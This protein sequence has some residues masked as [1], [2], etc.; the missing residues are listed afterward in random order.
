[1]AQKSSAAVAAETSQEPVSAS[2]TIP[3]E[4]LKVQKVNLEDF[5]NRLPIGIFAFGER[6]Q[7]LEFHPYTTEHDILL[8]RKGNED[9][10]D[11]MGRFLPEIIKTI[12]GH[13][14]NDIAR[15]L[16]QGSPKKLVERMYLADVLTTVLNIRL[17]TVGEDVAI[18]DKCPNC[19]TKI[20][21]NDENGYHDLGTVEMG[22]IPLL[23]EKPIFEINLEK[24]FRV[25]N[26]TATTIHVEPFK[27]FQ[28]S[29]LKGTP[30]KQ[31]M[32]RMMYEMV[33][34]IPDIP[35]FAGIKSGLFSDNE[36]AALGKN[37][38]DRD[39]LNEAAETLL[40]VG[41]RMSIN[42]ICDACSFEYSSALPWQD[43]DN[44]L[45]QSARASARRM[46][47]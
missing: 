42:L 2:G 47:L 17:A 34:G 4:T 45:S 33:C 38:D 1:M 13:S 32:R 3:F 16:G 9:L 19:S 36:Y 35:A 6:L 46:D 29:K 27:L 24:G 23:E 41:P 44:F 18:R 14:L 37:L 39:R 43:V 25:A 21:D 10:K 31:I 26:D 12:G 30:Q 40:S 20:E 28:M 5:P 15:E 22:I 8:T 11:T 7:E